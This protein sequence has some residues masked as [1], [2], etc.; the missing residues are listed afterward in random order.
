MLHPI[1]IR[2]LNNF[3][4]YVRENSAYMTGEEKTFAQD[5][6][7]EYDLKGVDIEYD[8]TKWKALAAVYRRVR[9]IKRQEEAEYTS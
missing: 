1:N 3:F 7:D 8:R 9:D 2:Q 6:A 5:L 4:A